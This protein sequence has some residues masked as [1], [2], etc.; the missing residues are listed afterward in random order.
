MNHKS[1]GL[2]LEAAKVLNANGI[3]VRAGFRAPDPEALAGGPLEIEFF[4]ENIGQIHFSIACGTDRAKLR[5]AFFSFTATL[6]GSDI[7]LDDP[8]ARIPE[9]GG[10]ASVIRVE[11]GA[12][13]SQALLVN[14]F[15][16]LEKVNT[17]MQP[18]EVRTLYVHCPRPLPLA[19]TQ[20]QAFQTVNNV[21]RVD[22]TLTVRVRRDDAALDALVARLA[23]AVRADWNVPVA[24]SRTQA[25]SQLVA[26]R[27]PVALPY[28]KALANHPDPEVWIRVQRALA[29]FNQQ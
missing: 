27:T 1:S 19:R 21:P 9:L 18:G 25:I 12:S 10:P 15:I 7:N 3:Q 11:A 16:R 4:V 26:L 2:L 29:L 6:D 13:Y 28:L 24:P 17:V 5:P 14:E 20:Q 23:E 8:A 22:V